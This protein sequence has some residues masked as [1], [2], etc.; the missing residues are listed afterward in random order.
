MSVGAAQV[1]RVKYEKGNGWGNIHQVSNPSYMWTSIKKLWIQNPK[2]DGCWVIGDG[3]DVRLGIDHRVPGAP[4]FIPCLN[5]RYIYTKGKIY[6][7]KQPLPFTRSME[8][9]VDLADVSPWWCEVNYHQ[10][11][12]FLVGKLVLI[13]LPLVHQ[14]PKGILWVN[15]LAF[16]MV[17]VKKLVFIYLFNVLLQEL[18]Y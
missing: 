3:K 13:L 8:S 4:N 18:F 1:F 16:S 17:R 7:C 6:S 15:A 10:D 9:T 14:Y 5:P 12:C 11:F 2:N